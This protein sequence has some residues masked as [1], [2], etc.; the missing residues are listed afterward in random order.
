MAKY[1]INGKEM[2]DTQFILWLGDN[3]NKAMYYRLKDKGYS[4]KKIA[5]ILDIDE[6]LLK[7]II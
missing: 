4:D 1:V 2:T 5:D 7:N 6:D 3:V